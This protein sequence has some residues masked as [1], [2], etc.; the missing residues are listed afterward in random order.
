MQKILFVF[1]DYIRPHFIPDQKYWNN[2][3]VLSLL[4]RC[5]YVINRLGYDFKTLPELDELKYPGIRFFYDKSCDQVVIYHAGSIK[6]QTDITEMSDEEFDLYWPQFIAYCDK[7]YAELPKIIMMAWHWQDLER[8]WKE[9]LVQKPKYLIMS[10]DDM[11][12]PCKVN[13]IG[14]NE[15]SVEDVA[16][17][18]KEREKYLKYQTAREK[19]ISNHPDYSDDVWRGPQDNEFEADIMKYYEE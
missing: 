16:Y 14:K 3:Y 12:P 8:Q 18:E 4:S 19:Y 6:E 1:S 2:N 5:L 10:I 13:M 7:R 11:T 17:F 15:L 9:L